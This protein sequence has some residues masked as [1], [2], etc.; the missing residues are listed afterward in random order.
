MITKCLLTVNLLTPIYYIGS[1][2]SII[3]LFGFESMYKLWFPLSEFDDTTKED[4]PYVFHPS[5]GYVWGPVI[6][7]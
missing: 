3:R 4:G 2:L 6:E 7:M 5:V 1:N